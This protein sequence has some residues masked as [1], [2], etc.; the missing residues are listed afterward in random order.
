MA[1]S[2][3]VEGADVVVL[4]AP[5]FVD[6]AV[7]EHREVAADEAMN[8]VLCEGH[9]V[10]LPLLQADGGVFEEGAEKIEGRQPAS[11]TLGHEVG[12]AGQG[13]A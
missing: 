1:D 4:A 10:G 8:E 5:V 12:C 13:A 11:G 3:V 9:A 6:A 2:G 7:G